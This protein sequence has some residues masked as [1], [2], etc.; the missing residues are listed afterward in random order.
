MRRRIGAYNVRRALGGRWYGEFADGT[1]FRVFRNTIKDR[2]MPADF[3][4]I[5]EELNGHLVV[6]LGIGRTAA[7]AIGDLVAARRW[8]VANSPRWMPDTSGQEYP[9]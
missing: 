8:R 6:L 5:A 2:G 1:V 7:G 4:W 3:D 9:G